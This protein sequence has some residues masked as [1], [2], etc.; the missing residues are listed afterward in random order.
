MFTRRAGVR[1]APLPAIVPVAALIALAV[2]ACGPASSPA[3]GAAPTA[4]RPA[5][6]S[7][8]SGSVPAPRPPVAPVPAP[9]PA[10]P[11]K[12]GCT[13]W[14][15]ASGGTL[16]LSFVPVSVLRCVTGRAMV[17][18][19]GEWL[20]ATLERADNQNL[21]PLA[22]ALRSAPGHM[23]PGRAC[24]E[25]VVLPPDIVLIGADGTMIRPRFP[26][27]GCGQVQQQVTS[28]LAALRWHA[29]SQRLIEKAP[30]PPA[31]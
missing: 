2:S 31:P 16:P 17:P 15:S 24:P 29:V 10:A 7:P 11:E 27:T 3:G 28:A 21:I 6:A 9:A 30:A 12:T 8:A 23:L 22:R 13:G 4:V 18:G 25:F 5:P 26:V 1:R 20:A 14:P 19:K